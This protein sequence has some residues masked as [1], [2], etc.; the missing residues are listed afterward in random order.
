[1]NQVEN[2][3]RLLSKVHGRPSISRTILRAGITR[4]PAHASFVTMTRSAFPSQ[5]KITCL[6]LSSRYASVLILSTYEL[7]RVCA[8]AFDFRVTWHDA[9]DDVREH[10][11]ALLVLDA[12]YAIGVLYDFGIELIDL[13]SPTEADIACVIDYLLIRGPNR[14]GGTCG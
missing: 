7:P 10:D 1:M 13:V 3:F 14:G 11:L 12:L 5:L 8:H 4:A 9:L 6:D 2:I